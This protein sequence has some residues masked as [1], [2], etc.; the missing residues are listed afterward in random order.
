[1]PRTT[2]D[3]NQLDFNGTIRNYSK[4]GSGPTEILYVPFVAFFWFWNQYFIYLLSLT[5]YHW[6]PLL[7]CFEPAGCSSIMQLRY[8]FICQKALIFQ[9]SS[10]KAFI[11][12]MT[13][14]IFLKF[15]P[16]SKL[17]P[18]KV[19]EVW[20][21]TMLYSLA[22]TSPFPHTQC[23]ISNSC[24]SIAVS[25]PVSQFQQA[26]SNAVTYL[27]HLFCTNQKGDEHRIQTAIK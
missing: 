22:D 7:Y 27:C 20:D 15:L 26:K 12:S 14:L 25:Y 5:Q 3:I 9:S 21:L 18:L 19:A 16:T 10:P 6:L 2:A 1:M 8:T 13:H 17:V 23:L 24:L 4:W 11:C